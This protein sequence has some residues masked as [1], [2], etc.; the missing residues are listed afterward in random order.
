MAKGLTNQPLVVWVAKE[1][2]ERPE[3]LELMS[4][5]HT[6][7]NMNHKLQTASK[8]TPEP[9]LILHPAAH[10]YDDSMADYLQDA[11]K[12]ARARKKGRK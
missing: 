8:M 4:Q 1:F 2:I 10:Y 12:A 3:I 11:V 5:G 6:V 7:V 9:D